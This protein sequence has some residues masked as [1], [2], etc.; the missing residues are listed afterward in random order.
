MRRG[1][2]AGHALAVVLALML[3]GSQAQAQSVAVLAK[4]LK[5]GD[6]FRVR[7]QAAL[8]LGASKSKSAVTPL[9]GGLKDSNTTVR[10]A[11]AS[12]LGRLKL[13]GTEC[14]QNRLEV[15]GSSAVKSSITKAL[16][17]IAAGD[18]PSITASTSVYLAIG[19]TA[20][21]SGIEDADKLVQRAMRKAARSLDGYVVAPSKETT[22]EATAL[23]GKFPK[24]KGF[25]LTPKVTKPEYKGGSLT[26]RFEL[27]IFTYPGRALKGS[28]PIRLTQQDVAEEDPAAEK[29]LLQMAA[30]RAVEKFSQNVERIE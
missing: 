22:K 1:R 2:L 17:S 5:D 13:G 4:R 16:A 15:E 27:S 18:A 8:A 24:V 20:D 29:E 30:E 28:V 23:L 3:A 19:K 9:C 6:D 25:Y 11:S 21:K 26:V 12:A 7:T 10:V 14:L